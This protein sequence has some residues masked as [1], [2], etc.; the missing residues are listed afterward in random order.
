[1]SEALDLL[2][3]VDSQVE[4][5]M[6]SSLNGNCYTYASM[7]IECPGD[8]I[9]CICVIEGSRI[10][11]WSSDQYIGTGGVELEFTAVDSV[12][13]QRRSD[14]N[15]NTLATLTSSDTDRHIISSTLHVIVEPSDVLAIS[16]IVCNNRNNGTPA[17]LTLYYLGIP[18]IMDTCAHIMWLSWEGGAVFNKLW[19][20]YERFG[21]DSSMY[22]MFIL[23]HGITG[24]IILLTMCFR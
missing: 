14:I 19:D 8:E 17:S 12:E 13:F 18:Y 2:K 5:V 21:I 24:F 7:L 1:M 15:P 22:C 20:I 23:Y 10:L 16:S 6:T 3:G 9:N 11:A 4:T